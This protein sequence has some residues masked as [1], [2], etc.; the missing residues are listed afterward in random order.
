MFLV[1]DGHGFVSAQEVGMTGV[2]V[3]SLHTKEVSVVTQR[4]IRN[5]ILNKFVCRTHRFLEKGDDNVVKLLFEKRISFKVW[6]LEKL[7]ED[8]DQLVVDQS[9]T[10]QTWI[11]ESPNLLF[12]YYFKRRCPDEQCWR[13]T[14]RVIEDRPDIDI[15]NLVERIDGFYTVCIQLVEYK[16]DTSTARQFQAAEFLTVSIQ[17]GSEFVAEFGDYIQ[18]DVAAVSQ[19][20]I[21]ELIEFRLIFGERCSYACLDVG[22][23]V[24]NVMHQDLFAISERKKNTANWDTMFSFRARKGVPQY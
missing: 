5:E 10:F 16:A 14:G 19:Q 2:D 6:L 21:S 17:Y 18:N 4:T 8:S 24:S 7:R 13:T 15:F 12:D 22:Q 11:F 9:G 20:R 3:C 23:G 1:H